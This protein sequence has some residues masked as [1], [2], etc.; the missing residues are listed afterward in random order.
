[1][2][3]TDDMGNVE[4]IWELIRGRGVSTDNFNQGCE[5]GSF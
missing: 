3:L 1:M 4:S 2:G 5:F